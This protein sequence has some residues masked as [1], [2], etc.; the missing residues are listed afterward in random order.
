MWNRS[1]LAL[2]AAMLV[3]AGASTLAASPAVVG[4]LIQELAVLRGLPAETPTAAEA[5]LRGAGFELPEFALDAPLTEGMVVAV[6]AALG[7]DVR[8]SQ[9]SA[10][11]DSDQLSQFVLTMTPELT[12]SAPETSSDTGLRRTV[13]T[14]GWFSTIP[15]L[16]A[17]RSQ[18]TPSSSDEYSPST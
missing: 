12:G 9:P 11:F 6:A 13:P 3:L 4:D 16:P 8:T 2:A 10:T 7:V 1:F 5:A 14:L 17:S 15:S 18:V